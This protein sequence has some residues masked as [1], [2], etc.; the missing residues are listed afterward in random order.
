MTNLTESIELSDYSGVTTIVIN[1]LANQMKPSSSNE[2]LFTTIESDETD[3]DL[4]F[5]L[6]RAKMA[7]TFQGGSSQIEA[8]MSDTLVMTLNFFVCLCVFA[9]LRIQYKLLLHY[10][11]HNNIT[12]FII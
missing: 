9:K 5:A 11:L 8:P 3:I 10:K 1:G 7:L 2:A 4:M 6:E 12:L